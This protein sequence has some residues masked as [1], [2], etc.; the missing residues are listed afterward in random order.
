M[1]SYELLCG[2]TPFAAKQP[3]QIYRNILAAKQ[4]SWP[5]TR[6]TLRDRRSSPTA[7][8]DLVRGLVRSLSLQSKL[9]GRCEGGGEG[10]VKGAVRAV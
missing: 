8:E 9:G 3:L 5:R 10:G 7:S 4:I 2:R 6:K 1:L